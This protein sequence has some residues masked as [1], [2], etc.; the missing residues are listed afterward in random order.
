[1]TLIAILWNSKQLENSTFRECGL[2]PPIGG[3]RETPK[4]LGL[5]ERDNLG[6]AILSVR[7]LYETQQSVSLSSSEEENRFGFRSV[8]FSSY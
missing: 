6:P 2:V 3:V 4:L 8:V 1:M 7:Y 5:L